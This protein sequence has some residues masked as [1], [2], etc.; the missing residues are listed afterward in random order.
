MNLLLEACVHTVTTRHAGEKALPKLPQALIAVIDALI[1]EAVEFGHGGTFVFL[2]PTIDSKE[3]E[4]NL[5]SRLFPPV[6]TDIGKLLIEMLHSEEMP[7]H[8][9]SQKLLLQTTKAVGRLAGVDGC[10]VLDYGL[11]LKMFGAR[12][13]TSDA[14]KLKIQTIDPWSH[15]GFE[16]MGPLAAPR[17][18]TLGTRHHFAARLCAAIPGTT[19]IVISQDADIRVFQGADGYVAD[20]GALAFIPAFSHVPKRPPP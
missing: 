6:T 3:Q 7:Y 14:V 1:S 13:T 18:N 4:R 10:V 11:C 15:R 2:P 8:E 17:L 5:A 20:C 9:F 16:E 12:I 19:A